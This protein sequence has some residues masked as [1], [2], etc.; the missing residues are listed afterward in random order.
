MTAEVEGE[1]E[2]EGAEGETTTIRWEVAAGAAGAA[3][4]AAGVEARCRRIHR[5]VGV[6]YPPDECTRSCVRGE[7]AGGAIA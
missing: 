4:A 6:D 7:P 2:E 1:E 5:T 3:G